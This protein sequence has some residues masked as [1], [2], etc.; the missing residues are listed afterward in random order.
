MHRR[1]NITVT[2]LSGTAYSPMR[3]TYLL[4]TESDVIRKVNQLKRDPQV[5][6]IRIEKNGFA[7]L[8]GF[9]ALGWIETVQA[10][11]H[12]IPNKKEVVLLRSPTSVFDA[13][14]PYKVLV[15]KRISYRDI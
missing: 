8:R 15:E 4:H 12:D 13:G 2:A 11:R 9:S 5:K 14:K 6:Q 7:Y 3:E 10:I 1:H